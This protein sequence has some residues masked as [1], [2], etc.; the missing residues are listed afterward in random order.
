MNA[1]LM[2][3]TIEMTKNEAQSAGRIGSKKFNELKEYQTAYPKFTICIVATPKR[4]S[5]FTG[6]DYDF[7]EKYIKECKKENKNE[8]LEDF[9]TL[10]GK[11]KNDS[12]VEDEEKGTSTPVKAEKASYLEVKAW[13]LKTF[14]EI[15]NYKKEQLKKIEAILNVA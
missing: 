6:L 2:N 8:I 7:M 15:E 4:K 12:T 13:F 5:Q 1:N 11:I 3:R 9:N 14:P 10:R